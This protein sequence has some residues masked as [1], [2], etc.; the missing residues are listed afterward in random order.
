MGYYTI[1]HKNGLFLQSDSSVGLVL[2]N[3]NEHPV[4]AFAN[5]KMA[6]DF[7]WMNTEDDYVYINDDGHCP[8]SEFE[9]VSI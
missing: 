9:V 3:S 6:N 7:L 1:K 4:L 8:V 5:E 2:V